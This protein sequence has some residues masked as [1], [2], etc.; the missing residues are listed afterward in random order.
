MWRRSLFS[1]VGNP[2]GSRLLGKDFN[3]K[4]VQTTS[5]FS[6]STRPEGYYYWLLLH[7]ELDAQQEPVYTRYES[8]KFLKVQLAMLEHHCQLDEKV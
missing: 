1:S 5:I 2:L 7:T 8:R 4:A 6:S 3:L